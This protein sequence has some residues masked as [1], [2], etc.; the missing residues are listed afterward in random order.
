MLIIF[1][2]AIITP[3]DIR[4]RRGAREASARF[5]SPPLRHAYA[6]YAPD[7]FSC[8]WLRRCCREA[9]CR[10]AMIRD[11][12][13]IRH[14]CFIFF[15]RFRCRYYACR[16]RHCLRKDAAAVAYALCRCCA[17]AFDGR[18]ICYYYRAYALPRTP[19][20]LLNYASL[21]PFRFDAMR[22]FIYYAID[23]QRHAY[24]I[25]RHASYF[26]IL[27]RRC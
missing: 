24:L 25:R 14:Y 10:R 4:C 2:H 16:R 27:L 18:L 12:M 19:G 7:V 21:M 22:R 8:C 6:Y 3:P 26:S 11:E 17:R 23:Y 13:P 1:F 5:S 20:E 15:R 9:A